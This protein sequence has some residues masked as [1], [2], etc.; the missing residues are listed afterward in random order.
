ME[1]DDIW[2]LPPGYTTKEENKGDGS[3]PYRWIYDEHGRFVD[4]VYSKC[5]VTKYAW[6]NWKERT[7]KAKRKE[8][9]I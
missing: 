8:K 5:F 7:Q 9:I 1:L 3:M 4:R 6:I 2:I